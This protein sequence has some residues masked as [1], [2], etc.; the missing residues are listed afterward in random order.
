MTTAW[1]P[2]REAVLR[3]LHADGATH[4]HMA[5]TLDCSTATIRRVL[6][7]FGLYIQ[8]AESGVSTRMSTRQRTRRAD[9]AFQEALL[10]ALASGLEHGKYGVVRDLGE[11]RVVRAIPASSE[12]F[13]GCGSPAA[14][15]A[16]T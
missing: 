15:T 10:G 16:E 13:S 11:P 3:Q 1:P 4:R 12:I 5:D 2:A 8:P 14:M 7:R 6:A 9:A